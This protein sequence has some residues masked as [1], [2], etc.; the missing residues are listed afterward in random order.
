MEELDWAKLGRRIDLW[1][2]LI[3]EDVEKDPFLEGRERFESSLYGPQN[4]IKAN[5]AARRKFLLEHETL[6]GDP[7]K[8]SNR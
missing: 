7:P 6:K 4:S 5:S 8:E 3:I 1:R 2:D